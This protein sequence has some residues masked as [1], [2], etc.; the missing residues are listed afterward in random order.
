MMESSPDAWISRAELQ[1]MLGVS[2]NTVDALLGEGLPYQTVGSGRGSTV[3]IPREAALAWLK[4]HRRV[5]PGSLAAVRLE[6]ERE[7]LRKIRLE[8]AEAEGKL[9]E[10][11]Q[12]RR[13]IVTHRKGERDAHMAW[14]MRTAPVLATELGVDANRMFAALDAAMR[15]HLHHLAVEQLG[16]ALTDH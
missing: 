5:R 6:F 3:R 15:E 10:R 14:V 16:G 12:V 4:K 9:V 13:L 7:R 8:L 1:R 2:R 11:E